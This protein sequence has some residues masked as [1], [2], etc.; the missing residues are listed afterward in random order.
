VFVHL[1]LQSDGKA[2]REQSSSAGDSSMQIYGAI[3]VGI[4]IIAVAGMMMMRK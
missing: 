4:A 2:V 3:A 1:F